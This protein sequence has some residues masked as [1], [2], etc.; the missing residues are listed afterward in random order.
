MRHPLLCALF[1][2]A[3]AAGEQGAPL[4][5]HVTL[6]RA[7]SQALAHNAALLAE[8]A[9]IAIADAHILT[10]GL[11]PNPVLSVSG[12]HMDVLG[13]GFNDLNGGGPTEI[14]AGVEFTRERG[15]KRQSRM[16]VA[17]AAK[18][19]AELHF[20][21]SARVLVLE[22]Q[23][24]FVDALLARDAL[25]LARENAGFF[26][27]IASINEARVKAGDLARVELIRSQLAALQQ[28]TALRQAETRLSGALTRVQ[29]LMGRRPGPRFAIA[30][31]LERKDALPLLDELRRLA[32]EQRPDLAALRRDA[33]RASSEVRLQ[34]ANAR[35]DLT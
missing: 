18:S 6:D 10:A 2:A 22:V 8:R 3:L 23:H 19:V 21:N 11:R 26:T 24:A 7:I 31:D 1:A 30:G 9:N 12:D 33:Q 4:F 28:Q 20:L 17:R 32:L 5:E 15:G 27:Q 29:T 14:V 13:S 16:E 35:P 34:L 25:E